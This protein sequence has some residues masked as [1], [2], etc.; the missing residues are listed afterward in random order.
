MVEGQ[1]QQSRNDKATEFQGGTVHLLDSANA[2]SDSAT[3]ISSNA[4]A[5]TTDS[6]WTITHDNA[7]GTTKLENV[8]EIGFGSPTGFVVDQIVIESS[9]TAGNFIIDDGPT[10]DTDLAG[11]GT[12]VLPAGDI[13]YTFGGE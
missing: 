3:T 2:I 4:S 8:D 10:G 11:D 7:A 6:D 1:N 13:A 9:T 5:S 12:T